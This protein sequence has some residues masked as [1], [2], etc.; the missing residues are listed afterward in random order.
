VVLIP[1]GGTRVKEFLPK[2]SIALVGSERDISYTH[3]TTV[4]QFELPKT[5]WVNIR[6]FIFWLGITACSLVRRE[7]PAVFE[8]QDA[9][10]TCESIGHKRYPLSRSMQ[11]I[12]Y[13]AVAF[14]FCLEACFAR[15]HGSIDKGPSNLF[16]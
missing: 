15:V 2:G 10:D 13:G 16:G 6:T 7:W 3:R 8:T 1:C 11:R 9:E 5:G 14:R 4:S 12:K